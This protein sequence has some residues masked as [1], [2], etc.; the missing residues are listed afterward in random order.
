MTGRRDHQGGRIVPPRAGAMTEALR[1]LGYSPATALADL[2]DNSISAGAGRV[3]IVA[4]WAGPESCV[5]VLDDGCGMDDA[6]L[7]RAMRLGDRDPRMTR[8]RTDLGR[9]GLGLKTASFSQGRRLTVASRTAGAPRACLR[10]DLDAIQASG[11][12]D[13]RLLE[14]PDPASADRLALLLDDRPQGTLVLWDCLDRMIPPAFTEQDLLDLLDAVERHLSMVFHRF[15]D[16]PAPRLVLTLNGCPV[17]PWDPFLSGHPAT[18]AS[19]AER[20]ASDGTPVGVRAYVLPHQDRLSPAEYARA[21][22]PDG[23]TAQQGFYVY[24]N[25]RLLVSGSWLGLG[26]GRA[27]T[28][29]EAHRLARIRLDISN[30]ADAAWHIDIRKAVA[31]PPAGLRPRL[32]SIAEDARHRARR[33]FAHRGKAVRPGH[34]GAVAQAWQAD[35]TAAGVRYRI[36]RDHPAVRAVLETEKPLIADV[37][38]MLRVIEETVPV[39][40]IW[41]DTTE[42][43]ETPR[44]RFEGQDTDAVQA[45]LRTV[46]ANLIG[47]RG[48]SP[49]EA[50]RRL[51]QTDPFHQYPDL[52]AALETDADTSTPE[53]VAPR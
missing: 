6:A 1:G 9:F 34:T 5:A 21:A 36:D 40:R 24:R 7:E 52:V 13:W 38:A 42:Q 8:A 2:V 3:D 49:A 47:P 53:D 28:K 10:W 30:A 17:V 43:R 12:E 27:W 16:G 45:V 18:W 50:R 26:S 19:P 20:L 44:T 11:G 29:E 51:L 25:D 4:H 48:L 35:H 33:V 32:T 22:G 23:W 37:R 15:L 46:Y 14:G 31:R 39:A 41:L